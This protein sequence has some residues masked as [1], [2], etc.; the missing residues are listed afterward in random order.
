MG[1]GM[2]TACVIT[3]DQHSVQDTPEHLIISIEI[4]NRGR[5]L[6]QPVGSTGFRRAAFQ[7]E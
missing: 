2:S 7:V 5:Q 1:N 4:S 6:A 3:S